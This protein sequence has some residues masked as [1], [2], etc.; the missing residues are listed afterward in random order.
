MVN[1]NVIRITDRTDLSDRS[2]L[3]RVYVTDINT[4][5][6]M[7][8]A[9]QTP[10]RRQYNDIAAAALGLCPSDCSASDSIYRTLSCCM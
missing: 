10:K 1:L 9:L 6:I 5:Q 3:E 4:F 2:D 7:S 8:L